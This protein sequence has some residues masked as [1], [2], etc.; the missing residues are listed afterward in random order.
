MSQRRPDDLG[1]LAGEQGEDFRLVVAEG[2]DGV[3]VDVDHADDE[4]VEQHGHGHFG[5]DGFAEFEVAAVGAHVGDEERAPMQRDPAGDA[6]A[7]EQ[8][9]ALRIF[10][11]AAE[12]LDLEAAAVGVDQG[13]GGAGGRQGA[14]DLVEDEAQGLVGILGV[15]DQT[16]DVIQ[17]VE[18]GLGIVGHGDGTRL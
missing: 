18:Y 15:A 7:E 4:A 5:A 6:L 10:R 2:V 1:G 13:D 12:D 8:L 16:R 9:H 14:H 17:R 11:Q 3:A